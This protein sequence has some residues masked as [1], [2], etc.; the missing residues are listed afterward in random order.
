MSWNKERE[1]FI[2]D[3]EQLK[4][5]IT[6]L[7][8]QQEHMEDTFRRVVNILQFNRDGY[9]VHIESSPW[10]FDPTQ[11]AGI[12][13]VHNGCLHHCSIPFGWYDIVEVVA[14]KTIFKRRDKI[15]IK[16]TLKYLDDLNQHRIECKTLDILPDKDLCIEVE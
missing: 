3:I 10:A 15:R 9:Y 4:R 1:K 2:N 11:R 14:A 13:F 6:S 16:V 12:D 5:E 8:E 7:V